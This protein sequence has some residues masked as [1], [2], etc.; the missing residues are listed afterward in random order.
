MSRVVDK[1]GTEIQAGQIALVHQ[2]EGTR[3]AVILEVY[4]D[5][6]TV[7]A[8]GHWVDVSINNEGAEGIPSYILEVVE[9]VGEG[10]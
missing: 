5:W 1:N 4:E 6:P 9:H 8:P 3:A 7:N 2:D 10:K